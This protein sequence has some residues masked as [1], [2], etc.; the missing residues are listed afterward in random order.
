MNTKTGLIFLLFAVGVSTLAAQSYERAIGFR[1]GT[2]LGGSYKKFLHPAGAMEAI[3]DLDIVRPSQ[4]S[5][6]GTFLYEYHFPIKVVDGLA[7]YL[8]PGITVGAKIGNSD[9]RTFLFG[10]DILGGVEYKLA[11]LPLCFAFDFDPK[12]YFTGYDS[13]RLDP[14]NA[15]L[16]LRY[17]F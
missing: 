1:A 10:A 16:T 8:G 9:N 12:I 4:M 17:T 5:V 11:T 13:I 3:F 2:M 6:R 7:W 15:G 14:A